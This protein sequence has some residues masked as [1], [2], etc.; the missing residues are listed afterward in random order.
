MKYFIL[1]SLFFLGAC[2]STGTKPACGSCKIKKEAVAKKSCAK[3]ACKI[4]K[5]KCKKK[6]SCKIDK[7]KCDKGSCKVKK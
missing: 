6:D 2:A 7:K 4:K 1:S 5:E 3:D